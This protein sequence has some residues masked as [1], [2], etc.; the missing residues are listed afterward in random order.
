MVLRKLFPG[1]W[2]VAGAV[3]SLGGGGDSGSAG[4]GQLSGVYAMV[5]DGRIPAGSTVVAVITGRC[6]DVVSR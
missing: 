3:P 6:A 5:T 1:S 4:A 2:R